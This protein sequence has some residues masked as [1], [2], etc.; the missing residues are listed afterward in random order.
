MTS[1]GQLLSL[2]RRPIAGDLGKT[3]SKVPDQVYI[4][5]NNQLNKF[6]N[7]VNFSF[8]HQQ[9]FIDE[10]SICTTR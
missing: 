4:I 10:L 6:L 9:A 2:F 8:F 1:S 5:K 3:Q 7:F